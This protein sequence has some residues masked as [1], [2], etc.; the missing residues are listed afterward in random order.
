MTTLR[1]VVGLESGKG[2]PHQIMGSREVSSCKLSWGC[3]SA[4]LHLRSKRNATD[5]EHKGREGMQ[6][7]RED[8]EYQWPVAATSIALCP[9]SLSQ[10]RH[11]PH[12]IQSLAPFHSCPVVL[13][14]SLRH[15]HAFSPANNAHA[16]QSASMYM[17]VL[18]IQP[19]RQATTATATPAYRE[20]S[21][22][23]PGSPWS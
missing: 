21:A 3:I 14:I 12:C 20:S 18:D 11:C 17:R 19:Q 13:A 1:Q 15:I 23:D 22:L 6:A 16:H 8:E 9:L 2:R 10:Y 5:R 7:P 4:R